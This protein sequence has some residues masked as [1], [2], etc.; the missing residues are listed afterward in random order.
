MSKKIISVILTLMLLAATTVM[1]TASV[2]AAEGTYYDPKPY[3]PSEEAKTVGFNRYFFLMP[4][5]WENDLTST[6]GI[7][8]WDG[9]DPCGSLD[10]AQAG[11]KWPGYQIYKYG[12]TTANVWYCDVPVDVTTIVFNN[13]LDGGDKSWDNFD[14]ERY[15]KAVQTTDIGSEYYDPGESDNYPDGTE[16]FNN[17]IYV[18][19][20]SKT[21][22]SVTGKL[23]YVGEWY[24]YHGDGQYDTALEPTYGGIDGEPP[25]V[26]EGQDEPTE[27]PTQSP[28]QPTTAGDTTTPAPATN[29][30]SKVSTSDTAT[31]AT[32]V[33]GNGTIATGT[34]SF[35]IVLLVVAA[36]AT[37]FV[38]VLRKREIEK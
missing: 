29:A 15:V 16:S 22:E 31:Q 36:A 20:P 24:F 21:S 33:A 26:S 30:T 32:T 38:I 8:W 4:E 17:M 25:H 34:L 14:E 27:P 9:T 28:T 12:D 6:A 23:T 10:G 3:T 11:V 35:A 7:Y 37:G 13:A 1:A 18:I 19:D 5:S 2:S